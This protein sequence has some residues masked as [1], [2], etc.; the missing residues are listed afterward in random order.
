MKTVD[1]GHV[2]DGIFIDRSTIQNDIK[3]ETVVKN[4]KWS[5]FR[6]LIDVS[7]LEVILHMR[8]NQHSFIHAND[9]KIIT[10]NV[11]RKKFYCSFL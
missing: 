10:F 2:V 4:M 9:L 11:L 3:L 6:C 5:A 1:N 8:L 7:C